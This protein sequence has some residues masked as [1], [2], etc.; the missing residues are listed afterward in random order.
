[1]LEPL[2]T[3]QL[4]PSSIDLRIRKVVRIELNS[5]ECKE[6]ADLAALTYYGHS[7]PQE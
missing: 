4:S 2:W 1:M 7:C 3:E 6:S 5:A